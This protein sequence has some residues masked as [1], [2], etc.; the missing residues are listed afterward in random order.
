LT[1]EQRDKFANLIL[2]CNVHHKQVDDQVATFTVERLTQIKAEHEAWVRASLNFDSQRQQDD[3]L[4][5]DYIE[6]W[7][8]V[9]R[10][11]DWDSWTSSL[12]SSGQPSL[13][14]DMND[15]LDD[16]RRWLLSRI[17]PGRYRRLEDAFTNFRHV[18]EDLCRT[19]HEHACRLSD[20]HWDTEKFYQIERWD[21]E[22]YFDLLSQFEE[23]VG[24]VED[25]AVEL[26]RAANYI[27]DM[28][29]LEFMPSFRLK[30]GVV[31][32]QAGPFIDLSFKTYR[33]EY[34]GDER[35]ET[36]YPGLDKFKVARFSRDVYFGEKRN[37]A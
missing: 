9:I 29:R 26:T 20:W 16:I 23:H 3:E 33:V 10:L 15:A 14:A 19:F 6:Y 30:E 8:T 13:R 28:V 11:D 1:V 32:I 4:Y 25:L 18:A 37:E 5:A 7:T 2:L 17:W 35:T 36:P 24:L 31:L 22:L 27:C 12:V 21:P 34:R